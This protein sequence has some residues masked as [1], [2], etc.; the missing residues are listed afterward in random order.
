MESIATLL[1]GVRVVPV[2]ILD[3]A[4]A[5]PAL[6]AA[7]RSGGLPVAEVTFR[8]A[9]AESAIRAMAE[10]PDM[11]VGAGTVTRPAQVDRALECGAKFIVSPAFSA[12]VVRTC[13]DRGVPVLPGV[14]TPSEIQWALEVGL[15]TVKFFP[16][17]T[18]GGVAALKAMSAPFPDM[19]FVPTGGVGPQNLRSYLALPSV[20]AVGGTWL[21]DRATLARHD[22]DEI[23]QL[24]AEAVRL[25]T[26]VVTPTV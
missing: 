5:A 14:A 9:A 21:V 26:D 11:L 4:A 6:A 1:Q 7:L 3:D 15:D 18:L 16:A 10:D 17:E 20:I 13:L 2:V 12:D 19:R 8:T 23:T 25:S 22:F 24:T